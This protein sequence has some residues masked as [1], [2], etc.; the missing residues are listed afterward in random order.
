VFWLLLQLHCRCGV[1]IPRAIPELAVVGSSSDAT[2]AALIKDSPDVVLMELGRHD[3]EPVS[4]KLLAAFLHPSP[5]SSQL[6]TCKVID[7]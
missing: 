6:T 7:D 3:D 5:S 2:L 4:E 1:G